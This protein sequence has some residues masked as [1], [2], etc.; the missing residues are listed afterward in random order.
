[1]T[2]QV[3]ARIVPTRQRAYM[4]RRGF[5][6]AVG[7]TLIGSRS[8]ISGHGSGE[9]Q[10][11]GRALDAQAFHAA[12]QHADTRFER[13]AYVERGRGAGALFL[14]GFPLNGYQWRGALERLAHRRRCI[15][16][17]FLG[18]GY[19]QPARDASFAPENQAE[20]LVTL[21]DKLGVATIDV[22]ANDSGGAVAQL[23]AVRH[24]DRVR[25]LLLTNCDTE[26]D[27][28]PAGTQAGDRAGASGTLRR[29]LARPLGS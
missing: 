4:H 14:H 3:I 15:A 22:V 26:L 9:A 13:I 16:P 27:S 20:M 23:L 2:P 8:G 12:R 18:L 5:L 1:M 24:P 11:T 19:T 7:V 29:A 6:G 21:L 25:T 17:D 28:P 10:E